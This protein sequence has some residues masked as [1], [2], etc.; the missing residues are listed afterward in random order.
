[1][2]QKLPCGVVVLSLSETFQPFSETEISQ[3]PKCF[4]VNLKYNPFFFFFLTFPAE[5]FVEIVII[6][7]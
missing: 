6:S 4:A 7:T 5:A 2:A 1:M 3:H